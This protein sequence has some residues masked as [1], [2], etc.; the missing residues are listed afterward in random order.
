MRVAVIGGG[1]AGLSAAHELL[2]RGA[3]PV[4]FES[5]ARAGGMV[6]TRSEQGYL[7]EDGPNFIARPLDVLLDAAGLRGEVVQPRAPTTRWVHLEGRL[8]K[9]PSFSLLARAGL[10]RA[11]LEPFI[12]KPLRDD[13]SLRQFL[14]RRLGRR[15]GGL[16][17]TVMSAGVYAGDPDSL[18]AREA[19][20]SL[21]ALAER[22]SLIVGA[23]RKPKGPPRA[24]WTLRHGLG[25]LAAAAARALGGRMRLRAPVARLGPDGS[26]W[27]VEDEPFDAVVLAVPAGPAATLAAAFAPAFAEAMRQL[28]SAPVSIV[29]LGLAAD[30]L[31]RGFGIIDADGTLHGIGTLLPGSMLPHRAPEGRTLVTAICGGARY[32]E[33]AALADAELVAGVRSDLRALWGVRDQPDYVRVVRWREAI[34]QYAPGHRGLV[35]QAREHLAG[36]PPI[37]VA[38]AAY[39]GVSVPDVALSGM[40]AA[41]RLAEIWGHNT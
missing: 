21:G 35:R 8:L 38:G 23:L 26:G 19:F 11:L 25:S 37:E 27:K 4:V 2:R 16:I 31:P 20:P 14:E 18:S 36:L 13:V 24:I 1:M 29:H 6:G 34:P 40:A 17:A 7:T 28:R 3:D 15:A 33:R 12:A 22:G 5:E 41:S 30:A 9:A 39:D 10:G 32:P